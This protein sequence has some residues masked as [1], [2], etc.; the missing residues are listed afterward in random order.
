MVT[1]YFQ[2]ATPAS[3]QSHNIGICSPGLSK[4]VTPF[5]GFLI[6][7]TLCFLLALVCC[8][9]WDVRNNTK[10]DSVPI[11]FG[12]TISALALAGVSSLIKLV[13][14]LIFLIMSN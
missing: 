14:F 4:D 2:A 11:R 7:F 13:F 10:H 3:I 12:L 5:Q 9:V 1:F 6:E 8:G